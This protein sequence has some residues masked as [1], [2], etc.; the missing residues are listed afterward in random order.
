MKTTISMRQTSVY[1]A[2]SKIINAMSEDAVQLQTA[3]KIYKRFATGFVLRDGEV[4]FYIR[5]LIDCGHLD[6]QVNDQGKEMLSLTP[7]GILYY[8]GYIG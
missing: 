3:V 7:L 6:L 1:G 8:S 5:E 4:E 2:V